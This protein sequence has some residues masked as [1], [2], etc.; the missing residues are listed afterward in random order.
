[1]IVQFQETSEGKVSVPYWKYEVEPVENQ[2]PEAFCSLV[3]SVLRN[4]L[5]DLERGA[6]NVAA[7]LDP[8]PVKPTPN[9]TE[10][11]ALLESPAN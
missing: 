1:M 7:G 3:H 2:T 5:N 11:S 6:Q 9:T 8:K 10:D 4:I